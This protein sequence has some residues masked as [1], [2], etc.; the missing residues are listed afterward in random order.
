MPRY[1]YVALDSRGLE[2][3]GS[4]DAT[5]TN[6][7]IGQLRQAGYF[8]TNVYEEKKTTASQGK[9]RSPGRKTFTR[10]LVRALIVALLAQTD[11]QPIIPLPVPFGARLMY[12]AARFHWRLSSTTHCQEQHGDR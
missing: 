10:V 12:Y 5:T 8:P 9:G 11:R 4:V 2:S 1:N 7:A 3:T 6:E